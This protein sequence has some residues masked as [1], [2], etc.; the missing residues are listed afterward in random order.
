YNVL[1]PFNNQISQLSY[2]K[3]NPFLRPEIVNNLELGYTLAYRYNFKL[4]YSRTT[5][6]ITRLIA[7]DTEDPRAGFIT[8]ANLADQTVLSLSVS[9]PVQITKWWNAYFNASG[10]HLDNQA[11][12]GN[13][14]VVDVQAFNYVIFQQ[15]TFDLPLELKAEVSGYYSGPG[16]WGGVF[17]YESNWG[18]NLGLQRK[19]LQERLN[20]RLSAEDL[21]YENGWDGYSDFNGLLSYGGGRWDSRRISLSLGYRFGNDNVKSRK[22]KTGIEAEAGRV[23]GD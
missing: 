9:A 4:A 15:H 10:S 12:Y 2:E 8:W 23:G 7:P 5:D 16:V 18:L 17:L 3:G 11:D 14:A 19:F 13:G 21:F 20:V 1:N 22:R 6:Q